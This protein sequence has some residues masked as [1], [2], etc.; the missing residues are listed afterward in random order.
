MK[1]T[2]EDS[3]VSFSVELSEAGVLI[4]SFV[5]SGSTAGTECFIQWVE[6]AITMV[7][8]GNLCV[9]MDLREQTSVPLRTQIR[10]GSWLLGLQ[11]K[12]S[13]IAIV[14]GGRTARVLSRSSKV[15]L[16]FFNDLDAAFLWLAQS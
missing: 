3:H 10:M 14:G 7:G 13:K 2:Y 1:E 4:S 12:I 5:G 6:E 11:Q 15:P 9:L 8:T 16:S